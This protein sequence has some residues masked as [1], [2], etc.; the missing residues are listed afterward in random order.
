MALYGFDVSLEAARTN[1]RERIF[2]MAMWYALP[3]EDVEEIF[4][5]DRVHVDDCIKGVVTTGMRLYKYVAAEE[6][7]KVF[8]NKVFAPLVEDPMLQMHLALNSG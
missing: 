5:H 3:D 2:S 4:S 8:Q 6:A 1:E 7:R